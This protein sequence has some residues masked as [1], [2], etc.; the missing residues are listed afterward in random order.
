MQLRQLFYSYDKD[1]QSFTHLHLVVMGERPLPLVKVLEEFS[2]RVQLD[3]A[4]VRGRT[5]LHWACDRGDAAAVKAL[6]DAGAGIDVKDLLGATP[7]LSGA[8]SGIMVIINTLL[9]AGANVNARTGRGDS[10]LHFASR[11][12]SEVAPVAALVEAGASV[13]HKNR[14]GNTAFAGAAMMNKWEIGQYLIQRGSDINTQGMYGDTPLFETIYH[15]SHEFMKMLLDHGA[16]TTDKNKKDYT[17]LHAA[18]FEGDNDTIKLLRYSNVE[19]PDKDAK[20]QLGEDAW[21]CFKRRTK[22][23]E[24]FGA[25][26]RELLGGNKFSQ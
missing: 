18:A 6:V 20:N 17:I 21:E 11:H 5:P 4:D 24:G 26:L 13:G 9:S 22:V 2:Y 12:Q 15:N 14:F 3:V 8:S 23:P 7:L 19:L 10:P 1:D 25:Q 16:R